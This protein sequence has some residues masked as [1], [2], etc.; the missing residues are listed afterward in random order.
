M[1]EEQQVPLPGPI[2]FFGSGEISPSGQ[3][4]FSAILSR[5]ESEPLVSIL[6]TPAGFELNSPQVAQN[7]ADFLDHHLQNF[8]PRTRLIPARKKDG[9]FS[10]NNPEILL[11]LL[12]SQLIFMGPGSPTYA[13]RMLQ[14]SL[15]W[16]YIQAAHRAG[17]G[18]AFS[19]AATIA[20]SSKALPVYEIYKAGQDLHWKA[21]LNLLAPYGLNLV[22]IP[23]WNNREGGKG[24]DTSRCFMGLKRFHPLRNLLP[25][26]TKILGI[27]E[28][29]GFVM[30]FH[31]ERCR[32]VGSGSAHLL[33]EKEE[34][35]FPADS[36][37]KL[38]ELGS[39]HNP[40]TLSGIR[41]GIIEQAHEMQSRE[42][43]EPDQEILQLA[44]NRQTARKQ[45]NWDEADRLRDQIE[46]AGWM[47]EDTKSGYRLT[48]KRQNLD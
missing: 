27:D 10:T 4:I 16:D 5:L 25:S 32:V 2:A 7:I 46:K 6:E 35:S 42:H 26:R 11:D 13:V 18:L 39:Y 40:Q 23:H 19:S 3:N 24:L 22:F 48:P 31:A 44:E 33:T 47:I 20:V 41:P 9:Q 38:S 36:E 14:D 28:H 1:K 17:V 29:T 43:P 45:H 21:G 8:H 15:A 12:K 30:D 37:I 34:T